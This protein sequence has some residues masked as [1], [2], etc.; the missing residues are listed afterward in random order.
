MKK[1]KRHLMTDHGSTPGAYRA[2][3]RLKPDYP[4]V[5]PTYSAQRQALAKQ[6]G[7]RPQARP[8]A[9]RTNAGTRRRKTA[10]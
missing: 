1:L 7:P 8:A 9:A 6:I 2:R 3:W 10:A 4:M 5:A